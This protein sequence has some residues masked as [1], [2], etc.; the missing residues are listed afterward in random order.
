VHQEAPGLF[1]DH[2]RFAK[3]FATYIAIMACPSK[4]EIA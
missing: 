3:K 2:Y 4:A 1:E